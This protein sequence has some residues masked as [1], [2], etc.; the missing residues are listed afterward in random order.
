[1]HK[2][3][4][5]ILAALLIIT[6]SSCHNSY[7]RQLSD[8]YNLS[9]SLPDSALSILR[10]VDRNSLSNHDAAMYALVYT[11]AQDKS[12]LD[13]DNDSLIA[14]AYYWYKDRPND[15]LYA[16][17]Q[18]YMGKY[19]MLNDSTEKAIACLENARKKANERENITLECITLEKL[20]V[21]LRITNKSKAIKYAR[22]AETLYN[23]TKNPTE[24]NKIY[25]KLNLATAYA[26]GDNVQKAIYHGH[27][28][29][30]EAIKNGDSAIISG[31]Y[32]EMANFYELV[33]DQNRELECAKKANAYQKGENNSLKY[34]LASA[35]LKADSLQQSY[36]FIKSINPKD[37][38]DK[39]A[40]FYF[41]TKIA[42]EENNIDSIKLFVDSADS[43]L[44]KM[45]HNELS[46]KE[47]YYLSLLKKTKE[48][49][50]LERTSQAHKY[51]SV[52]ILTFLF[53]LLILIILS[54]KSYKEK[55]S[56]KLKKEKDKA[57]MQLKYEREI[58]EKEKELAEKFHSKEIEHKEIQLSSMRNYLMKKVNVINKLRSANNKESKRL[59]LSG[60]E[61]EELEVFLNGVDNTFVI[62]IRQKFP[63]LEEKDIRLMML[64]RL[65]LPQ[66]ALAEIYSISEKAIKQK[67]YL[68]KA[69][70]GLDKSK[71]SLRE[72]IETF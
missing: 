44:V 59:L 19:Y 67:L 24:A 62:R 31:V 18:C 34:T 35:Y 46:S 57:R 16:D 48:K 66:K 70:V 37:L 51:F 43:Y 71:T 61:W 14:P 68:Y 49:S 39:Y 33:D 45:Y 7:E 72:F 64:L 58:Y 65:R 22:E 52:I 50:S 2:H 56:L 21:I 32:Q 17:C 1:M 12:G 3:I 38:S 8:A 69:K 63:H 23:K 55:S 26:F 47:K 11:R 9:D 4:I 30:Q 60:G 54:Y 40:I 5:T 13:V 25:L 29:L 15:S 36:N 42:I 20:S 6:V 41:L 28:A 53:F 27:Q 10:E